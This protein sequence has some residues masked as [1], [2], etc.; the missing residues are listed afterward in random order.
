M[1]FVLGKEGSKA[2]TSQ[3]GRQEVV[4][5]A[6]AGEEEASRTAASRDQLVTATLRRATTAAAYRDL[7]RYAV[8][9][10]IMETKLTIAKRAV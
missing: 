8:F 4:E 10:S 5:A 9:T 6:T 3:T 2:S 1:P 7:K